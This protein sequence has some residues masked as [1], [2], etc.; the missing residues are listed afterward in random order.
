MKNVAE[1]TL[2]HLSPL[3]GL[4]LSIARRAADMR[5]LQFGMI[6]EIEN[7][8]TVGEYALHIQ[9]PWRIDGLERVVTGRGDLWEPLET[10]D[11][12]D[13]ESW[14][15]ETSENLQDHQI[16]KLLGGFG[17]ITQSF[18]NET[19]YLIVEDIQVDDFGGAVILLSGGYRLTLFPFG[20]KGED[21]RIFQPL[22]EDSHHF[23]ISGGKVEE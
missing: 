12:F 3:I 17:P 18:V 19:D 1:Q 10:G 6:R 11:D 14:D 2:K 7:G 21:W 8:G 16:G 23:V 20:S 4:K 5:V 13:W 9:C 22:K 15:Y